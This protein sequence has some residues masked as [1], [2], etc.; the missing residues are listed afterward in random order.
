MPKPNRAEE[1]AFVLDWCRKHGGIDVL[2][3]PAHD[4][5]AAKFGAPLKIY[6]WGP[7]RCYRLLRRIK[8]LYNDNVLDRGRI[9]LHNAGPGF[10]K[11]VWAYGIQKI[12][13]PIYVFGYGTIRS[14]LGSYSH[15]PSNMKSC[16]F[17]RAPGKLF[18][19][20]NRY[21]IWAGVQEG[22]NGEV[23]GEVFTATENQE[24]ILRS[25]DHREKTEDVSSEPCYV[26]RLVP[27]K[28]EDGQTIEAYIY[29]AHLTNSKWLEEIPSG[30][31][32]DTLRRDD[33]DDDDEESNDD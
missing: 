10:P 26:R 14:D 4:Q 22:G 19:I 30:D 2:Q 18:R 27:V 25:F 8:E 28:M 7:N 32:K 31:W 23:Y 24:G 17:G 13:K 3:G 16:G 6:V 11:W 9:G 21:G 5:F 15:P 29:F 1:Q 33:D 12:M 20:S